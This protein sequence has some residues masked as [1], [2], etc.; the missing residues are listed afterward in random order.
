MCQLLFRFVSDVCR[1]HFR[2]NKA[3][4]SLPSDV[5]FP[6]WL[7]ACVPNDPLPIALNAMVFVFFFNF[8]MLFLMLLYFTRGYSLLNVLDPKVAAS[9]VEA[10][11]PDGK[12]VWLDQIREHFLHPT[13]DSFAAY[14]NAIL[15]DD[16]VDYL[17]DIADP[18]REE[19][20]VLSSEGSDRSREDLTPRSPRAGPAQGAANE[21]VNE[22]VGDDA[23]PPVDTVGQLETRKKK[24]L[25]KSE[26]MKKVEEKVTQAP[27]K[28][29]SNLLFLDYAVVSDTL[30]D[31]DA[32]DKR[33]ERD[34]NDDAT[35]TEIMEKNK[36]LEEKK[37]ELD[38]QAAAAL[39][40]KKSKLQKEA[41]PAPSES[42]IDL[43]VFSAKH[44]NLLEKIF[45]ASGSQG[46]KFCI[47]I[48][49]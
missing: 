41:P 8:V 20:I 21:P 25:E 12:P 39:A 30:T 26:K 11:L 10:I 46:T 23:D 32:G 1:P 34:P 15:G 40:A 13:S 43:G 38:E 31:L 6:H 36:V 14:A 19:V 16:G 17:D 29:P 33:V 35:L 9:M 4:V 47:C 28:Q 42:E 18:T 45:A 44:G 5:S 3:T 48:L 24:K 27:R 2:K 7:S 37:K 22:P 49:W